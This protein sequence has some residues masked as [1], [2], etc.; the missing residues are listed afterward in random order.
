MGSN[1]I[2]HV[3]LTP[4]DFLNDPDFRFWDSRLC[5]A[6]W[7]L[8]LTLYVNGGR[9]TDDIELL[10][11]NAQWRGDGFDEAWSKHLRKKFQVHRGYVRH[12]R[13]SLELRRAHKKLQGKQEAGVMGARARWQ[14]DC[15][16]NDIA[17]ASLPLKSKVKE[18]KVKI[19]PLPPQIDT[20]EFNK[21][22][23]DWEIHRI[24][25]R[26]ALTPSTRTRQIKKLAKAGAEQAIA[27]LEQSIE[28][29]WQGLFPVEG[30]G[31]GKVRP[32]TA[33][34]TRSTPPPSD[35]SGDKAHDFDL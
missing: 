6:Y 5:G 14:K 19:P 28:Q 9:I 35:L 25:I 4:A 24:E 8:I 12:K 33:R 26:H 30:K 16:S 29:G 23:H 31:H 10:Q 17:T 2:K 27:M 22:W 32:G 15:R 21:A 20:P 1:T 3:W 7:C 18:S 34:S 11:R 13:V